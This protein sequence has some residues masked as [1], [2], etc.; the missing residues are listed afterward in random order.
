MIADENIKPDTNLSL[1]KKLPCPICYEEMLG[2][3]HRESVCT[4]CG[5]VFCK[6]CIKTALG[7]SSKCPVCQKVVDLS[8]LRR[9]YF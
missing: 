8:T 7:T 6:S 4:P 2:A 9:L 5:H 3:E 1:A